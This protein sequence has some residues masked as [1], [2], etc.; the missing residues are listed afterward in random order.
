MAKIIYKVLIADDEYWTREKLRTMIDWKQYNIEFL[1]PAVDGEDVLRKV[2]ENTPDILITD[3]N[4]PFMNGVDLIKILKEEYTDIIIFVISGYDNF[5]Y[6]KSTLLAG[7]INYL[8]KPV[9]KIDLVNSLSKALEIISNKRQKEKKQE[10]QK[11]EILKASSF[12]QDRELSLLVEKEE[13]AY[14]PTIMMNSKIDFAG[15]SLILIKIHNLKELMMQY[16]YDMNQLS[17]SI[18]KKIKDVTRYENLL[19][20]NHIFR[21]NEFIIIT[22]LEE[23]KLRIMANQILN[24]FKVYQETLIS[25][26][27]SEHSYSIES[28]HTAYIETITM[29]MTRKYM[30]NSVMILCEKDN[31]SIKSDVNNQMSEE[32]ENKLKNLLRT[33]NQSAV[34]KLIFE[35]VGLR[36]CDINGWSFLEVKQTVKR[37][38]NVFVDYI[39]EE[40]SPRKIIDMENM[41]DLAIKT[42]ENLV[43]E[44]LC[45][46]LEEMIDTITD[47]K[48]EAEI[49]S[50]RSVV[51]LCVKYI[52]NNFFEELTLTSL[53]NKF[54]VESSYFSKI[55]RQEIG[56][57]LML[58]IAQKRIDKAKEYMIDSKINLTEIAFIVGYDDYTYFNRVFRKMTGVSP[59]E[60]RNKL[61]KC[62]ED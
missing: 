15:C 4:M 43:V 30:K 42:V 45:E 55:F 57:N 3:I 1:E 56:S 62:Q 25:I 31:S 58:Y 27:I 29:L 17:Y 9:T 53:A 5:D 13:T 2:K 49:G 47:L 18:K 16:H 11:N 6:V 20:F 46:V 48:V 35:T 23:S 24:Y 61:K 40:K 10:E 59:R 12:I 14:S 36:Y 41:I 28:I 52:D 39:S 26:V 32:L 34:K 44:N 7:A 50:I 38:C 19:I 22:E 60:Y 33:R 8:L 54:N 21:S 51:K 37:V